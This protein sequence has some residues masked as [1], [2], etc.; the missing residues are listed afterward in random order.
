MP[1]APAPSPMSAS[2]HAVQD[3]TMLSKRLDSPGPVDTPVDD[4]IADMVHDQVKVAQVAHAALIVS[5]I[6]E[7]HRTTHEAKTF[8]LSADPILWMEIKYAYEDNIDYKVE[9]LGSS[10][11]LMVTWPAW[12][13]AMITD[14]L[15]LSFRKLAGHDPTHFKCMFNKNIRILDPGPDSIRSS[16]ISSS[17]GDVQVRGPRT[18][19]LMN[20][21]LPPLTFE[22]L[23]AMDFPQ[24]DLITINEHQWAARKISKIDGGLYS[25]PDEEDLTALCRT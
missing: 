8:T 16:P 3:G 5:K 17:F 4:T 10:G 14:S 15:A 2:V 20:E 7:F 24:L 6:D 9:Y 1:P 12:I 13:R 19:E 21:H 22:Q 11:T 23:Y 18:R 25:P